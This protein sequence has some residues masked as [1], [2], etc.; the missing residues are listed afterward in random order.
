MRPHRH[1]GHCVAFIAATALHSLRPLR[2][3]HCGHCGCRHYGLDPQSPATP[4]LNPSGKTQGYK[5]G[6]ARQEQSPC[7]TVVRVTSNTLHFAC[8]KNSTFT[9]VNWIASGA[10]ERGPPRSFALAMTRLQAASRLPAVIASPIA[11]HMLIRIRAKQSS[12]ICKD[13]DIT[14]YS[15]HRHCELDPQSRSGVGTRRDV[16]HFASRSGPKGRFC[17]RQNCKSIAPYILA[18]REQSPRPTV[19]WLAALYRHCGHYCFRHCGRYRCRHC[20]HYRC[21]HCGPGSGP[22]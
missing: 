16:L 1:C 2:C 12:G 21:R 19:A 11:L 4:S 13:L 14:L 3:I 9:C 6:M 10:C 15:V 17:R 7:P 8:T 5:T 22:G 20:G 18:R